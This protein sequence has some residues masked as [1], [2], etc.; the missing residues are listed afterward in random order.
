MTWFVRLVL[1]RPLLSPGARRGARSIAVGR[2]GK[3]ERVPYN[4]ALV[5]CA[6]QTERTPLQTLLPSLPLPS[7]CSHRDRLP[8]LPLVMLL[9][10]RLALMVLPLVLPLVLLRAPAASPRCCGG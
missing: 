5:S 2:G 8:S 1:R 6:S 10:R 4:P 3:P 9:L 7:C